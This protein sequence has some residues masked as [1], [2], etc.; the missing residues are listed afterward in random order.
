VPCGSSVYYLLQSIQKYIVL[1]L[2]NPCLVCSVA[3]G[4]LEPLKALLSR[5]T[6]G[7]NSTI[8][9]RKINVPSRLTVLTGSVIDLLAP[10]FATGD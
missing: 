2:M 3:I 5:P 8:P 7:S 6:V 9:D 4:E 1:P 10:A